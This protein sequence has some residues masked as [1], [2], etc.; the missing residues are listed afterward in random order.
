M[1]LIDPCDS[2]AVAARHLS[3]R[4][5]EGST[6]WAVAPG[7]DDHARHLAVEFVH[8]ASVGAMAVPA[9]AVCGNPAQMVEKLREQIRTG[10]VIVSLGPADAALIVD[11][12]NRA[13]AW[14]A[15]HVHLGWAQNPGVGSL[16]PR[17]FCVQLGS[18]SSAERFL[19]RS[20]HLLWELTFIC[21]QNRKLTTPASQ[22]VLMTASCSV[23]ADEATTMEISEMLTND[24]ARV[25]TACGPEVVDVSLISE[26]Q[27]HDL[28]LVHAGIAIR[29]L[30]GFG[31]E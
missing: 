10:D 7:L 4:I 22:G 28:L 21:L 30:P 19:T 23:C 20:Y 16:D 24:M 31:S 1:T 8:P 9:I 11:L 3:S 26:V 27:V 15:D 12:S 25:R 5:A 13:V 2:L 14:G 18:D 29:R 17:S 6:L